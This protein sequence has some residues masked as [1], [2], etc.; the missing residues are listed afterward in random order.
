MARRQKTQKQLED[1]ITKVSAG[2]Y[3]DKSV[4]MRLDR[5]FSVA[6]NI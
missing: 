2:M 1:Y 3:I 6:R 4:V 5:F